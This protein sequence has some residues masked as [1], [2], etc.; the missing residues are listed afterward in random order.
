MQQLVPKKFTFVKWLIEPLKCNAQDVHHG[1]KI[2]FTDLC[3]DC[4]LIILELLDLYSLLSVAHMN[5][6]LSFLAANTFRR[7]FGDKMVVIGSSTCPNHY[8]DDSGDDGSLE[9]I[10]FG[11]LSKIFNIFDWK[12]QRKPKPRIIPEMVYGDVIEI[13]E[14]EISLTFL[15]HFGNTIK[16]LRI[17]YSYLSSNQ[18]MVISQFINQFCAKYLVHFEVSHCN[19]NTLSHMTRPF[20]RLESAYFAHQ[21]D[22]MENSQ[23]SLDRL[24]PNIRCLSLGFAKDLNERYIDCYLQHLEHFHFHMGFGENSHKA[25]ALENKLERF[26]K[27]NNHIRSISLRNISYRFLKILNVLLPNCKNLTLHTFYFESQMIRFEKVTKFVI[28]NGL[29]S[30]ENILFSN[31]DELSMNCNEHCKKWIT[32]FGRHSNLRSL[33]IM[34]S[35]IE[36]EMLRNMTT[37]L[38]N[39]QE[40]SLSLSNGLSIR[41][42]S[43][44]ELMETHKTL[45]HFSITPYKLSDEHILCK[46]TTYQWK[47]IRNGKWLRFERKNE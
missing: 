21:L 19:G 36:D 34:Q 44:I 40:M 25:K 10:D 7:K 20:E 42:E 2:K 28:R 4:H 37:I 1:N 12:A 6:Q 26:I 35:N 27:N 16:K 15:A 14:F 8:Y 17:Y 13:K 47:M 38:T 43:I 41:G 29:G 31:L 11:I 3:A 39:L 45:R 9:D 22:N 24:F 5:E 30:P 33:H 23:L 18:S 32:F 46:R